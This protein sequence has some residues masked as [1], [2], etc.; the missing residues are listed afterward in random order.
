MSS[1]SVPVIESDVEET[2]DIPCTVI[3][4][5]IFTASAVW[6][7]HVRTQQNGPNLICIEL[8]V[9]C[10]SMRDIETLLVTKKYVVWWRWISGCSFTYLDLP[11]RFVVQQHWLCQW[12][13]TS[14][15]LLSA[16]ASNSHLCK[17]LFDS[18]NCSAV[19]W[20]GSECID[21]PECD[22][23][24]INHSNV[25]FKNVLHRTAMLATTLRTGSMCVFIQPSPL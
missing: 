21:Q 12:L 16:V 13:N 19:T 1:M 7:Q 23:G 24:K 22:V 18:L 3:Q 17:R 20:M 9:F 10:K 8:K 15:R 11:W 25:Y 4:V 2:R 6:H 5:V 14:H